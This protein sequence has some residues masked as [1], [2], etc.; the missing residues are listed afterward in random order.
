MHPHEY[1]TQLHPSPFN[2]VAPVDL[3]C[4][5]TFVNVDVTP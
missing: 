4:F 1:E 2:N 5:L 3:H